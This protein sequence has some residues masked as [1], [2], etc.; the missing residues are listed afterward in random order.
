MAWTQK[1]QRCAI[2][3]SGKAGW[4]D[5]QRYIA[6]RHAGCAK[7]QSGQVSLKNPKN[8][9]KAFEQYMA[10]A[11]SAAALNGQQIYPPNGKESWSAVV[12]AES[13]RTLRLIESIWAEGCKKLNRKFIEGGLEGFVER[14]TKLDT[15]TCG[16]PLVTDNLNHC[17]S[18]QLYRILEGLKAWVAREFVEHGIAPT[19]FQL[20]QAQEKRLRQIQARFN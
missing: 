4:N 10:I 8:P 11:E 12:D 14:M 6:M 13:S 7:T 20:T 15:T 18:A 16:M 3:A 2:A 17:D 9:H 1:Q 19:T 5:M